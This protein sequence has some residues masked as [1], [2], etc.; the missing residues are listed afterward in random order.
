MTHKTSI[1]KKLTALLFT[2]ILTASIFILPVSLNAGAEAPE[3]VS[4]NFDSETGTLTISGNGKMEEFISAKPDVGYLWNIHAED[5]KEIC[6]EEGITS[7]SSFAFYYYK[8]LKSVTIPSTVQVIDE[9]AFEACTSLESVTIPDGVIKLGTYAFGGCSSLKEVTVGRTLTDI[10]RYS[11]YFC[12]SLEN[13]YVLP[14]NPAYSSAD[15]VL[16]NKDK[17]KLIQYPSGNI[18]DTYNV[19]EGVKI[20]GDESFMDAAALMNITLPDSVIEIGANPFGGTGFCE[21]DANWKDDVLY[22]G[23]EYLIMAGKEGLISGTYEIKDGT[24][25]VAGWAFGNGN[26]E[27]TS[28]TI[29]ASV[30]SIGRAA[31]RCPSISEITVQEGNNHFISVD[32]VLFTKDMSELIYYP[33]AKSG[34]SYAIPEGV[35]KIAEEAITATSLTEITIPESVTEIEELGFALNQNLSKITLPDSLTSVGY[36]AFYFCDKLESIDFGSN[37]VSIEDY[38][39]YHCYGLA[40]VYFPDTLTHIGDYAFYYCTGLQHVSIPKNIQKIGARAFFNC[41]SLKKLEIGVDPQTE[42]YYEMPEPSKN[43]FIASS[44]FSFCTELTTVILNIE[45]INNTAFLQC[46]SITELIISNNLKTIEPFAF[47]STDEKAIEDVYYYGTEKDWEN[48]VISNGN[49]EYLNGNFHIMLKSSEKEGVIAAYPDNCFNEEITLSVEDLNKKGDLV[50]GG[51]YEME[52]H[53]RV[54]L[55]SIKPVNNKSET[56]QPTKTVEIRLPLP[57]DVGENDTVVVYHMF[58][59]SGRE[60]FTTK[61]E[62]ETDKLLII[63]GGY[64]IF[65]I[66]HFSEFAIYVELDEP[67]PAPEPV[68]VSSISI[69]SLP[70]KTAYTYKL[71]SLDLSG[72]ALTVT[73]SDGTTETVTDT[74]AMKVSGFDNTKTGSQT[75]TVEYEGKTATFE[76]TV[77]YVWWQWI[78]KI[79]LLGFLWY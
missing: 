35:K 46:H 50:S 49:I 19:P 5:I 24:K 74:S 73:Y 54:G 16:F 10:D 33:V 48:T 55:Y 13:F 67:T 45:H 65:N 25:V 20:I 12:E 15:G 69:A 64:L 61:P 3:A 22:I 8:N 18:R 1:I 27:A 42:S 9:Y 32:N 29:P 31:F 44:A 26:C 71:D 68:T 43:S 53:K 66:N 56:V 52:G 30:V 41:N 47:I 72:L 38:A 17:T 6:I 37:L 34:T 21:N 79:L 14:E 57:H 77:T 70:A 75:V 11:F 36:A 40:S 76:V 28:I 39:F 62:K 7:I 23:D 2:V 63:K 78:I 58:S 4:W 59:E 51:F 60:K